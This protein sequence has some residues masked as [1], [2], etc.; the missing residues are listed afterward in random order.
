MAAPVEYS[1]TWGDGPA[2]EPLQEWFVILI[3]SVDVNRDD[4]IDLIAISMDPL[5][6]STYSRASVY[7]SDGNRGF[8]LGDAESLL[9]S[10]F[11]FNGS[12]DFKL[13]DANADGLTDVYVAQPGYD[14]GGDEGLGCDNVVCPGS[15]N[16]LL[17]AL[18][19]GGFS[20]AT[21][22]SLVPNTAD[23]FTHTAAIA[24]VDCDGDVDLFE[25]QWG[26]PNAPAQSILKINDAGIFTDAPGRLPTEVLRY[27]DF[28]VYGHTAGS[29]FCDLDM[30]GDPDLILGPT[31]N[32]VPPVVLENNG[33]GVF[34]ALPY[35][36]L[37]LREGSGNDT[38]ASDIAC[39][40]LDG[41]GFP[42]IAYHVHTFDEDF[43]KRMIIRNQGG[44]RFENWLSA[45]PN[46][47]D[48]TT[49]FI[50]HLFLVIL[51]E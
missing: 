50:A 6:E 15:T 38:I 26:S 1:N 21:E 44:M 42:D 18:E 29:V 23:G 51:S 2:I 20:D 8:S 11:S 46:L 48:N 41:N 43:Q 24:D 40:D 4:I 36:T 7:I 34:Q 3:L 25:G 13:L 37:P 16:L 49:G 33:Q 10:N 9:G 39:A 27:D 5:D 22:T 31:L 14:P 28:W 30:D 12:R 19:G 17:L 35:D 45:L 47:E 32:D